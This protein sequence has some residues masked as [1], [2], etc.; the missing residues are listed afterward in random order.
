MEFPGSI[1]IS[2]V[3]C[4]HEPDYVSIK[5]IDET[6]HARFAEIR[7][8]FEQLGLAITGRSEVDCIVDFREEAPIGKRRELKYELVPAPPDRQITA[9]EGVALLAPFE[10]DGW[11]GQLR[12]LHN[13]RN[14]RLGP[15]GEKLRRVAFVRYIDREETT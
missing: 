5:I 1:S 14:D 9:E 7:M 3:S 10:V 12:E 4:S 6:S 8:T 15:G 2:R 11:K 13:S